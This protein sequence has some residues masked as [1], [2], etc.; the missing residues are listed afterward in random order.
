MLAYEFYMRDGKGGSTLI[1]ILPE[2]RKDGARITVDSIMKW[3][4]MAAGVYADESKLYYIREDL[5]VPEPPQ[6]PSYPKESFR[7]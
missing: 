5:F 6:K 2:R 1:G 4:I 3:G 7:R